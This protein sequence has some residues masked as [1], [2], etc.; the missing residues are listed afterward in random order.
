MKHR[1]GLNVERIEDGGG[2]NF[3]RVRILAPQ[4]DQRWLQIAGAPSSRPPQLTSR[5]RQPTHFP[6]LMSIVLHRSAEKTSRMSKDQ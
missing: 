5:H 6:P 4:S 1:L 2:T 3:R